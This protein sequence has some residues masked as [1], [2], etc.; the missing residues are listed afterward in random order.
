[1]PN[2]RRSLGAPTRTL[3]LTAIC[4]G[5]IAL[6]LWT[7]ILASGYD[8]S[9]KTASAFEPLTDAEMRAASGGQGAYCD[10]RSPSELDYDESCD[11]CVQ[12]FPGGLAPDCGMAKKYY[13]N[14]GNDLVVYLD[15]SGQGCRYEED[16]I[17]WKIF[18]CAQGELFSNLCCVGT[19]CENSIG[20]CLGFKCRECEGEIGE[21]DAADPV[22]VWS[23]A[24]QN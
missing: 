7:A 21:W 15:C 8:A 3:L 5:S 17:T 22:T 16:F 9:G 19:K 6:V 10:L 13:D 4:S 1:M 12:S 20:G 23:C 18:L 24:P 11:E 2:D 14:D